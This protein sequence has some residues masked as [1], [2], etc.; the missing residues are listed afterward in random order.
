MSTL[1]NKTGEWCAHGCARQRVRIVLCDNALVEEKTSQ[2]P[3]AKSQKKT[4]RG[5]QAQ[6]A[7]LCRTPGFLTP[8]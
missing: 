6:L 8:G 5:T 3:K 2:K 1:L 4:I 7:Q